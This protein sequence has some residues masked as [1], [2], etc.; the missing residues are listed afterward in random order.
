MAMIHPF[1]CTVQGELLIAVGCMTR[2]QLVL[3]LINDE[4]LIEDKGDDDDDRKHFN[5]VSRRH[6]SL[7]FRVTSRSL[8]FT[9][10]NL[11]LLLPSHGFNKS[12]NDDRYSD[13]PDFPVIRELF[14]MLIEPTGLGGSILLDLSLGW[15]G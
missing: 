9:F 15:T 13:D 14:N 8:I 6:L 7:P 10:V 11:G 12:F 2:P 1:D 4:V 3:E 5:S